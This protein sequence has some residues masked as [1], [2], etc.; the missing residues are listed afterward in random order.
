MAL[1]LN[2]SPHGRGTLQH[3][4][5]PLSQEGE[6]LGVRATSDD[7]EPTPDY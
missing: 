3:F 4:P 5:A 7:K 1:T 6:G 2:P